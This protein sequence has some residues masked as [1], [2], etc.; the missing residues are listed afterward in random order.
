MGLDISL[1]KIRNEKT[2]DTQW[3]AVEDCP[4]LHDNYIDFSVDREFKY[5]GEPPY[6][7]PV[8]Y[9]DEISYQRKG[10]KKSFYDRYDPDVFI[11]TEKDLDEL[12]QY[13]LVEYRKRFTEEFIEKFKEGDNLILMGY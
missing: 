13:I 10:V 7:A 3:L 5:K 8:Y 1:I 9:F 2:T 12:S 11:Q 4:E 6:T